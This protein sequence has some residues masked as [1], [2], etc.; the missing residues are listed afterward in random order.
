MVVA[1]ESFSIQTFPPTA[2][3]GSWGLQEVGCSPQPPDDP[4]FPDTAKNLQAVKKRTLALSVLQS[5][6]SQ[7]KQMLIPFRK[8]LEREEGSLN[9][10][11]RVSSETKEK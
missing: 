8:G 6:A 9:P 5:T 1:Q 2:L 10:S 11:F 4:T 3:R 7:R